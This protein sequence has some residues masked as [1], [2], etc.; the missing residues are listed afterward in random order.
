MINAQN[1]QPLHLK[2]KHVKWNNS[3]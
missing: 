1:I 3:I 2:S